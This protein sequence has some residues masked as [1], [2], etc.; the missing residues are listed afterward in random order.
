MS[1][2]EVTEK[3]IQGYR[4]PCPKNCPT[5][6]YE[7][8]VKCWEE[9]SSARPSIRSVCEVLEELTKPFIPSNVNANIDNEVDD[10][11]DVIY[12]N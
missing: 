2:T 5:E 8:M 12:N 3:V 10:G 1:N 11:T 9:K 4:L 7:V 6:L